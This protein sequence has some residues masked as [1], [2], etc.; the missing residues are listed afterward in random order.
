L[1]QVFGCVSDAYI[2]NENVLANAISTAVL[3]ALRKVAEFVARPDADF[4]PGSDRAG[5]T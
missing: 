2:G 1:V 5:T 3:I 4:A